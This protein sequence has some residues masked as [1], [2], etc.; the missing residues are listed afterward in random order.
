MFRHV[1]CGGILPLGSMFPS[2]FTEAS[3]VHVVL[4]VSDCPVI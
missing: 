4:Q 1:D 3:R 2:M